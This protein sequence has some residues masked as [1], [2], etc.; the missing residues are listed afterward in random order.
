[1]ARNINVRAVRAGT[2]LS[3]GAER[4]RA[5]VPRPNRPGHARFVEW[6]KAALPTVGKYSISRVR[7]GL[8]QVG[9][10]RFKLP[11]SC[12]PKRRKAMPKSSKTYTAPAFWTI[13]PDLHT[14]TNNGVLSRENAVVGTGIRQLPGCPA[15]AKGARWGGQRTGN[16]KT[17]LIAIPACS[18]YNVSWPRSMRLDRDIIKHNRQNGV[19][20]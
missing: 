16:V 6:R 2:G 10:G 7:Q 12:S 11:N 17:G 5:L 14:V 3:A 9:A 19:V 20:S 13:R 8:R 18:C 1:M 15:A 4:C